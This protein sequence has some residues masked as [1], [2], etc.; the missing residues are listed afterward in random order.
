MCA[1]KG[2]S[3]VYKVTVEF[4][5]K[6]SSR[7]LPFVHTICLSTCLSFRLSLIIPWRIPRRIPRRPRHRFLKDTIHLPSTSRYPTAV[8][9]SKGVPSRQP[10]KT[11]LETINFNGSKEWGYVAQL[12]EWAAKEHKPFEWSVTRVGG[13]AHMPE[14]EAYPICVYIQTSP[15]LN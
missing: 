13:Q 2:L 6:S 8:T 4:W 3:G 7:G 5:F 12:H 15:L 10:L 14:F 9:P 1:K 11:A